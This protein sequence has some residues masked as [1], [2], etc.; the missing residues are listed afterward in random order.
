MVF[1][2]ILLV[3]VTRNKPSAGIHILFSAPFN[4]I[5]MFR[6]TYN[7]EVKDAGRHLAI[8]RNLYSTKYISMR[9]SDT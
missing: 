7:I 3:K 1:V 6:S 4:L 9:L 2:V 5:H 8:I